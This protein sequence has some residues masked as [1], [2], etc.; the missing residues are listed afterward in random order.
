MIALVLKYWKLMLDI[1]IVVALCVAF[2]YFDPFKMFRKA[3]LKQTANMVSSVKDI[4]ELVAA[5]Y[6]GEVI[7]FE[8]DTLKLTEDNLTDSVKHFYSLMVTDLDQISDK[9]KRGDMT[10][11]ISE[12]IKR[13]KESN[14]DLYPAFMAFIAHKHF[15]K[16]IEKYVEQDSPLKIKNGTDTDLC[17]DIRDEMLKKK[18]QLKKNYSTDLADLYYTDYLN[19]LPN[20][21]DGFYDFYSQGRF[22]GKKGDDKEPIILIARGTVKAGFNFGKLDERN[23]LYNPSKKHI[24][25]YGL[26]A[27]VLDTVINPWFIPEREVPGYEF[28]NNPKT[29]DYAQVLAV[30]NICRHKLAGKALEAGLLEQAQ[31]NGREVL[32]NFFSVLLN[33]PELTVSFNEMP[34]RHVMERITRDTLI[35][36]AEAEEFSQLLQRYRL[37][38]ETA[39]TEEQNNLAFEQRILINTIKYCKFSSTNQPFHLF[40]L[41]FVQFKYIQKNIPKINDSVCVFKNKTIACNQLVKV[42][43]AYIRDTLAKM[44]QG[45]LL[46]YSTQYLAENPYWYS[47]TSICFI[48]DFNQTLSLFQQDFP[49]I[50]PIDY[51]FPQVGLS[52]FLLDTLNFTQLQQLDSIVEKTLLQ[53]AFVINGE[54]EILKKVENHNAQYYVKSKPIK[55]FTKY[56][57]QQLHK[58]NE[59]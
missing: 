44:E 30:K 19:E 38:M 34:N 24:K 37:A 5:E 36:P 23:F 8:G 9:A 55:K 32:Q 26:S 12:V 59:P 3:E 6:Y 25:L 46:G 39:T 21:L 17:S 1:L 7:S 50:K 22:S 4:G 40:D 2:S 54:R 35:T 16:R 41:A 43:L 13:L 28:V 51:Q 11:A 14:K 47:D 33:E 10:N 42:Y 31:Q 45:K 53:Q 20:Y 29:T 57:Q 15:D 18:K 48:F 27:K 56:I 58:N 52:Q 49:E